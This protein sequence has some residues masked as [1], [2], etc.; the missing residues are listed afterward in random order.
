MFF[1]LQLLDVV[2]QE[3]FF[4]FEES[5]GVL[6]VLFYHAYLVVAAV[7]LELNLKLVVGF[8]VLQLHGQVHVFIMFSLSRCLILM[9]KVKKVRSQE[10][11]SFG[12]EPK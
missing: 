2:L 1:L 8:A 11:Q 6:A 5:C 4:F 9:M 10:L 12:P 7:G 3:F